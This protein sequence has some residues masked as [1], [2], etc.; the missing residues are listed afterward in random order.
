MRL[1]LVEDD[2][3]LG[4][5][6]RLGLRQEG[7][8]VDWL[9]DGA[10]ALHA[11]LSEDFDLLVLDLGLPRMSGLQVL[12]ELRR[13][14]SAL[15]VLILTARDATEDR[16]A[17][18]DAG[19]DDY[20]VKPFDLDELKARLRA[21][22]RRSAGRAELRIEHAGVSL[23]PSSQQVSYQGKP[24]PMTPKEYLLLHELLSQPG[25]V[26]TRE[27]LAQLLYGWDEE[28]ESN[29]LEVHIHHLRKKLFSSLIRTVRGVGY[30]VEEQ[31]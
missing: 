10:S 7:Y 30:L 25:K 6:L 21:L 17:G 2:K 5:G 27:R 8:T 3:A 9:E 13:S 26:L 29:T 4:E 15:P 31:S 14:G 12:R 28:A 24:V 16:I 19:A 23:D 18:L 11:L 22:L 1:L 20:L